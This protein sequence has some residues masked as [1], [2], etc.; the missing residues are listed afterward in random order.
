[1]IAARDVIVAEKSKII[2]HDGFLASLIL[3]II[4]LGE[5]GSVKQKIEMLKA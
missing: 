4:R 5:G 1:M 3:G 2:T